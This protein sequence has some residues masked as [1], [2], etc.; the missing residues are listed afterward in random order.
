MPADG[1]A[2]LKR[3][4]GLKDQA[5]TH[6]ARCEKMAP[7]LAPSRVGMLGPR[8]P[9]DAQNREVYDSTMMM[10]AE[11]MAQFIAG[12]VI[13]PSQQWGG[14]TLDHP[15]ATARDTIQEWLE[16]CRDRMFQAYDASTFYAEAPEALIDW[17]G[18]GTGFLV[19]E[20]APASPSRPR[21]GFRGLRFEAK[22]TGRFVI[23]DGP[24]GLVDT[25]FDESILTAGMIQR[26]WP[27]A[28]L[29]EKIQQCLANGKTDEPFTIVHAVTPRD[30][31]GPG[32]GAA[33]S[34]PWASCWIEKDSKQ[35]LH[36]SGYRHFN[37]AV[38]RY[39]RTPGE[40]FGRGRGDHAF[41]DAWSLNTAKRYALED[42]ALKIRPPIMASHM[43]VTGTL[44][45]TPAGFTSVNSHG[46]PIRDVLMPWET[47]SHPEVSQIKEEELRKSI[48][49]IFFVDHILALM[50]VSKSEMT[51][52]EYRKKLGL[53]FAL[54]GPVYGR[55][56]REFLRETWEITW[57]LMFWGGAFS[58]P[59]PEV[60]E[61][62]GNIDVQFQNPISLS[63]RAG[64]VEAI[65]MAIADLTPVGAMYPQVWDGFDPD[66]TRELVFAVRGVPA[67]VARNEQEIQAIRAQRAKTEQAEAMLEGAGKMA[68]AAGKAAPMVT[69]MQPQG[70]A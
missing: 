2:L 40:V 57:D 13:N 20:E 65:G 50:E 31:P 15:N 1:P 49:Q 62:D 48:R 67:R 34:M 54:I 6:F 70:R 47:G 68:E 63:Q 45:I 5:A 3:Y 24:E 51:A 60:F 22:K 11:L 46:K 55:L 27:N 28:T 36:E 17:G 30:T 29:P 39:H 42:W 16:E 64:E 61:T 12:Q 25:A 33:T 23:A 14:M 19:Q 10:A 58:P 9:G 66:K 59:P 21:P 38:P 52:F 35:V 56:V 37:A 26:R 32:Y 8:T 18:F 7:F 69:A 41:P 44:R 53:L 43:A 4:Q